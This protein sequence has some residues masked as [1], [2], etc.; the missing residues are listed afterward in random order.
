MPSATSHGHRIAYAADGDGD[1]VLFLGDVGLGAWQWG[2]QQ[3]AVAGPYE[4]VVVETR[5][6]GRSDAPTGP[7]DVDDLADDAAVVLSAAGH[8][9][10][11]VVGAG[12][13]AAVALTLARRGSRVTSLTLLGAAASGDAFDPDPLRADPDDREALRSS[14][15]ATLSAAFVERHPEEVERM[16]EWRA[17]EDAAP[18]ARAAQAAAL[19]G[20][21]VADAL[22]EI[23]T[24]A[25]VVHGADDDVCPVAAG[26]R[27]AEGL[28]R[29][30][31]A[32]IADAGHL[33]HVEA[34]RPVN[35]RLLGFLAERA[36]ADGGG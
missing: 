3:P 17:A 11:H 24:P 13:G 27:L 34:S 14:L 23:T 36:N 33:A 28:P 30:E 8:R 19:E 7:Y 31:F 10:A 12:L 4:G 9:S 29:G 1:A 32:A 22:Y 6:T 16:V 15:R 26:E 5:G 35:D 20:F 18:E 25:L 2:W 21:D